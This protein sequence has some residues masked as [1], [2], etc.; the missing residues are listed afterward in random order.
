[1]PQIK[2]YNYTPTGLIINN[3]NHGSPVSTNIYA[4]EG[5]TLDA[6]MGDWW[7]VEFHIRNI[8]NDTEYLMDM[9]VYDKAGNASHV[10]RGRPFGIGAA[11]HGGVWD[12]FFFG[13]NN[14]NSWDWGPTMQSHYYVDDFIVDAG[15]K[16]QIGPRYFNAIR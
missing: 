3:A 6:W 1:V 11:A 9:W 14:A 12:Q 2:Q 15:A 10:M 16:G 13:G 7:G 8:N 5:A 4:N